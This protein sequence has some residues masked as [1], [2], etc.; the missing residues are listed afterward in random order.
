MSIIWFITNLPPPTGP[1]GTAAHHHCH[2]ANLKG[3]E[4]CT[5]SD[6]SA[7]EENDR[8][9]ATPKSR[10]FSDLSEHVQTNLY[11]EKSAIGSPAT[12]ACRCAA[13]SRF[14]WASS[15]RSSLSNIVVEPSWS[16][17]SHEVPFIRHRNAGWRNRHWLPPPAISQS[18]WTG[19]A[20]GN[21]PSAVAVYPTVTHIGVAGN[22]GYSDRRQPGYPVKKVNGITRPVAHRCWGRTTNWRPRNTVP[23]CFILVLLAARCHGWCEKNCA[24]N[25][26][27]RR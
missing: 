17:R 7:Q 16:F 12:V 3:N 26:I 10:V 6:W 19:A 8:M 4:F 13:H 24:H 20:P 1:D 25:S 27:L 22:R 18:E 9:S 21:L 14:H 5:R 2:A 11:G 23:I 15:R